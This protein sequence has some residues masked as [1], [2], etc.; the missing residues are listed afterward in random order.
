MGVGLLMGVYVKKEFCTIVT[1]SWVDQQVSREH[2]K[3]D[4]KDWPAR[5]RRGGGVLGYCWV[6][7]GYYILGCQA[8]M[9]RVGDTII[10][11]THKG[12]HTR[13]RS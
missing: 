5:H 4:T 2:A 8:M 11:R 1:G 13:A 3:R 10:L 6:G 7:K 9:S 12:T